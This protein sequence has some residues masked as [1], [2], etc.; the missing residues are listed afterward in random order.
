MADPSGSTAGPSAPPTGGSVDA[1]AVPPSDR[2]W[3]ASADAAAQ[4]FVPDLQA[5]EPTPEDAHHLVRVLRLRPGSVVVAADGAGGW[6]PCRLALPG[7][8]LQPDGPVVCCPP[9]A[10]PVTVAFAPVK[11]DRP[12]WVVQK[13]TELGVDRIV[14]LR[15]ERSVVRWDR[16]P[17]QAERALD[18]LRRVVAAAAAQSRRPWL[19]PV[20]GI[21]D[22]AGLAGVVGER[23]LA[24]AERGGP[25]PG[26]DVAV[27]A[28]GPE[29]GWAPA[30]RK[31]AGARL[32]G[33]GPGVLRAETASVAAGVLLCAL[34]DGMV[35]PSIPGPSAM[36]RAQ[37]A[38][39]AAWG[40]RNAIS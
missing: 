26:P 27:L 12:E 29:G 24:L 6:R 17:A 15:A 32:V 5:P 31:V 2:S 13:L 35:R 19:P 9:P 18:R 40:A 37:G 25:P 7:A 3:P 8:V 14:V 22:V 16:Q 28:V 10:V 23:G 36:S 38:G 20:E 33:L 4:V 30:E 1:S 39:D 11:G 21:V 34:R